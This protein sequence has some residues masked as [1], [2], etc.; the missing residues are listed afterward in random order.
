MTLTAMRYKDYV[1][2]HNPKVYSITYERNLAFHKVPF[3]RYQIQDM[4][5]G[6][7]VMKGTGAFVGEDAYDQFKALATVFYNDGAGTLVHPIWQTT[8]A[9]F[10]ELSLAQEPTPD[11]V[12][13]TFTF[14][15][16]YSLESAT[17]N[18]VSTAT[19]DATD[20]ASTTSTSEAVYHT[21]VSGE[22]LWGIALLYGID[23]ND[24]I[25]LNPQIKNP[26][27]ILVGDKV[28]VG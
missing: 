2:P 28:L 24:L 13:Y 11:Y 6:Q 7:R 21:V 1:W 5:L 20:T 9:Y 16:D 26:N 8:S 25:A 18:E 4:G 10:A 17:L 19:T 23:L 27:L 14:W 22:T 3:G 15:E 12:A